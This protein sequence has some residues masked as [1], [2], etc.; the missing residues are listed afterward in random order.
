MLVIGL[1]ALKMLL[2]TTLTY[3]W[4]N[5]ST[6]YT[7]IYVL[8]Y[9]SVFSLSTNPFKFSLF[10]VNGLFGFCSQLVYYHGIHASIS[11]IYPNEAYEIVI[12]KFKGLYL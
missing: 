12:T 5:D 10:A 11:C 1:Y 8:I 2:K 3:T 4:T 7:Q 6:C 9:M